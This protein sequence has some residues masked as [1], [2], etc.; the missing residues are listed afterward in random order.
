MALKQVIEAFD[1]L[2]SPQANAHQVA[3]MVRNQTPCEIKIE[4]VKGEKGET[5]FLKVAFKGINGKLSGGNAPTMGIIGRVGGIGARPERIGIVSDADGALIVVSCMLKCAN[6]IKK[7]DSFDGDI[8]IT[9]HLCPSA[10]TKPHKP[11]PGWASPVDMELMNRFE[12]AKEMDAI[13]SNDATKANRIINH[14]GFAISPVVKQGYILRPTDEILDIM[15]TVSGAP[16]VIFP[17]TTADITPYTND[18]YHINSILQPA[19]VTDAPVL[20]VATTSLV[21]IA[22]CATGANQ[23]IHIEAAVRFNI[24]V[25]KAFTSGSCD[26]Y[27]HED[28]EQLLSHYGIMKRFQEPGI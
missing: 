15:Q 28:F 8:I 3:D 1:L 2:D 5:E 25:A 10:P 13:L 4:H 20:G 19:V 9:T 21:P 17:L 27:Y 22:G 14:S 26:I 16:P 12:V 7:G 11:V 6:M 24:E 23:L 18:I